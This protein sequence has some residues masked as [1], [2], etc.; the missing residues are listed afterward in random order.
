MNMMVRIDLPDL[1]FKLKFISYSDYRIDVRNGK[2]IWITLSTRE[3]EITYELVHP[4]T[5]DKLIRS[6]FLSGCFRKFFSVWKAT[7]FQL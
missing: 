1:L 3:E 4:T 2:T 6:R 5:T 7:D